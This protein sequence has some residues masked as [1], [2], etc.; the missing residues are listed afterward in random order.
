MSTK[1]RQ[2]GFTLI[3]LLVTLVIVAIL[4][5]IGVPSFSNF[6]KDNRRTTQVNDLITAFNLARSEAIKRG[7]PVTVCQS[8][9]GETCTN[10]AWE[11][12]WIIFA[13]SRDS[14]G[15]RAAGEEL[16]RV[17]ES[18]TSS[19]TLRGDKDFISYFPD[20]LSNSTGLFTLCDDRGAGQAK[21]VEINA[22]GRPTASN[23]GGTLTCP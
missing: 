2:S 16:L 3:E 12:G 23:N 15:N 7:V 4:L 18:L 20:G 17:R 10:S 21:A 1:L 5:A 19:S 9:D 11:G 22:T 8:D 14:L 13:D 6:I